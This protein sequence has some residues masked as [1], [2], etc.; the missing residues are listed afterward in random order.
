MEK[1]QSIIIANQNLEALESELKIQE[2]NLKC[3]QSK[4]RELEVIAA[5]REREAVDAKELFEAERVVRERMVQLMGAETARNKGIVEALEQENL[6]LIDEL[7]EAHA[8]IEDLN[9]IIESQTTK[10][11]DYD[12]IITRFEH[13]K[14][15]YTTVESELNAA[16]EMISNLEE[17][18][19]KN[20]PE[21]TGYN[22]TISSN[23]NSADDDE[24]NS[25]K[26]AEELK[27]ATARCRAIEESSAKE[28]SDLRQEL[29]D[30]QRS[31]AL[32]DAMRV[33]L[34]ADL[35]HAADAASSVE[36]VYAELTRARSQ[37]ESSSALRE[38][39]VEL[40]SELK[41]LKA[42]N[43]VHNSG[44]RTA[45]DALEIERQ[46]KD[47]MELL[48]LRQRVKELE[49]DNNSFSVIIAECTCAS[50][51][52]RTVSQQLLEQSLDNSGKLEDSGSE[53]KIISQSIGEASEIVCLKQENEELQE[54]LAA[55]LAGEMS[56]LNVHVDDSSAMEIQYLTNKL[57]NEEQKLAELSRQLEAERIQC[58]KYRELLV[59]ATS[60]ADTA[61]ASTESS[62]STARLIASSV[63]TRQRLS[64][65]GRQNSIGDESFS[66]C[67]Q[68]SSVDAERESLIKSNALKKA[69]LPPTRVSHRPSRS[70]NLINN[71]AVVPSS[72]GSNTIENLMKIPSEQNAENDHDRLIGILQK[73]NENLRVEIE[74]MSKTRSDAETTVVEKTEKTDNYDNNVQLAPDN[75]LRLL[76]ET[77]TKNEY[78]RKEILEL[79]ISASSLQE[80][81]E[82]SEQLSLEVSRLEAVL[83][84]T[85]NARDE[86]YRV[87]DNKVQENKKLLSIVETLQ[88]ELFQI[89][90]EG[91]K[92]IGA[93]DKFLGS[94]HNTDAATAKTQ[95]REM[96]T[97]EREDLLLREQISEWLIKEAGVL[98]TRA[99]GYA[100]IL[101]GEGI[102]S[103]SR[104]RRKLNRDPFFLRSLKFDKDDAD[105]IADALHV[106]NEENIKAEGHTKVLTKRISN[107]ERSIGGNISVAS[108]DRSFRD[109]RMH[110]LKQQAA[111]A[112]REAELAAQNANNVLMSPSL[113]SPAQSHDEFARRSV[114]SPEMS[115]GQLANLL[116][117]TYPSLSPIHDMEAEYRFG[118]TQRTMPDPVL[119]G[120]VLNGTSPLT[121]GSLHSIPRVQSTG[122]CSD[123]SD[124]EKLIYSASPD[125]AQAAQERAYLKSLQANDAAFLYSAAEHYENR[126]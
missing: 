87:I 113:S 60:F 93:R 103:M 31:L 104:V 58:L 111:R 28:V 36:Q 49:E 25:K 15:M 72:G 105:E 82:Q 110:R 41:Y 109:A 108:C 1:K 96:S 69:L 97:E 102:G 23:T 67:S 24:P 107:G 73:E 26:L 122:F 64:S 32:A 40:E 39:I 71:E 85:A 43:S 54:R 57:L 94:G 62:E 61:R 46:K 121:S 119:S 86:C 100:E 91:E 53:K 78:L 125:V 88:H 16:E 120:K 8:T 126:S 14:N 45:H 112:A 74:R 29:A 115:P 38:S 52:A 56:V 101:L 68:D 79:Q 2:S 81:S 20:L 118:H 12:D 11:S 95:K 124:A 80:Q 77:E 22:R 18:M 21:K 83:L 89:R 50:R 65:R 92:S 123:V 75:Y 117:N 48:S 6:N 70:K 30:T 84:E 37:L 13:L 66:S 9:R 27:K 3:E 55:A 17:K 63:G 10:I 4:C 76:S 99:K 33:Q 42:S 106:D 35:L 5:Q 19:A 116:G 90:M 44:A 114:H 34:Q 51:S 98:P 7:K 59:A 47:H